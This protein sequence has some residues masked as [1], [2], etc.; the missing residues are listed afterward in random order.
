MACSADGINQ[1]S[2][3]QL[4]EF[5]T[6]RAVHRPIVPQRFVAGQ[7]LLDQEVNGAPIC[8]GRAE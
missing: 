1:E 7:D 6:G 3:D 8:R 5:V 2:R 4:A